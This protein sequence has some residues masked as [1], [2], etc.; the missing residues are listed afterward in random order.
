MQL[1]IANSLLRAAR[2]SKI[3]FTRLS[4]MDVK[5]NSEDS[6]LDSISLLIDVYPISDVLDN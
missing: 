2:A 3:A 4:L 5:A 6:R 1:R